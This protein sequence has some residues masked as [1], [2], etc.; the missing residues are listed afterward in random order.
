MTKSN[1]M[2]NKLLFLTLICF[3]T[4]CGSNKVTLE[5]MPEQSYS[6]RPGTTYIC[7]KDLLVLDDNVYKKQDGS[8]QKTGKTLSDMLGFDIRY[9]C[10]QYQNLIVTVTNWNEFFIFN[11]DTGEGYTCSSDD[12]L[13]IDSDD[14]YIYEGELYYGVYKNRVDS[15]KIIK[16]FNLTN[17]EDREIYRSRKDGWGYFQFYVR[18]DGTIFLE[19]KANKKQYWQY[20][21]LQ[22]D[23]NG[24]YQEKKLWR[25]ENW[26]SRECLALNR[27][28]L[29]IKGYFLSSDENA[30]GDFPFEVVV[31]K[32]DGEVEKLELE[33]AEYKQYLDIGYLENDVSYSG[34]QIVAN[35]TLLKEAE[36]V[37][38]YDY[39]GN[40]QAE[41][42]LAD[43]HWLDRGFGMEVIFYHD[44]KLTALYMREDTG[45]LYI[46]QIQADLEQ[47]MEIAETDTPEEAE[48]QAGAGQ[49][50][51]EDDG[52]TAMYFPSTLEEVPEVGYSA[53]GGETT[54][55]CYK[56]LLILD[57]TVYEKENG[58]YKI[59]DKK[60]ED[61]LGITYERYR[62]DRY[63][64]YKNFIIT[65]VDR[66]ESFLVYDMDTDS[67]NIYPSNNNLFIMDWYVYNGDIY[68]HGYNQEGGY[69]GAVRSI[70]ITDG[71][72]RVVYRSEKLGMRLSDFYMRDDGTIF[73]VWLSEKIDDRMEFWKLQPDEDGE[74]R[75]TKLCEMESW[76]DITG[77]GF[78]QYGLILSSGDYL[79]HEGG[80]IY[81]RGSKVIIT[82]SGEVEILEMEHT[83]SARYLDGGYL[84]RDLPEPEFWT[85]PYPWEQIYNDGELLKKATGVTFYD[86]DGNEGKTY[87][88]IDS[89]M[90]KEGFLMKDLFYS[91]GKI[92]AIF[93]Q[94]DTGEL[95]ISQVWTDLE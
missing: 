71:E 5:E 15:L 95:Y 63:K 70:S 6:I 65:T 51:Y 18:G 49:G 36:G 59:T 61:F 7:Y 1:T 43:K 54:Y 53:A 45:E 58:V 11:M 78:S 82:D 76:F 31:I 68:Y 62:N 46:T 67:S 57:Y 28:G 32:D 27:H 19:C 41:Y 88:L 79:Y 64:Q 56:D 34:D 93:A 29:I 69:E 38:F 21:M 81:P 84:I 87:Q 52:E 24:E 8:Y 26:E 75:E 50:A 10:K 3:L 74:Y 25:A 20:Y 66:T 39:N 48:R 86:Y 23:E 89:N 4:A 60:I 85:D 16:K 72:D 42:P 44:G 55:I 13:G 14:W 80:G 40:V 22:L 77:Q 2:I 37:T 83:V 9:A 35:D 91:D 12:G 33:Y 73:W 92:T 30:E 17:Q 47:Y 94:E 90:V